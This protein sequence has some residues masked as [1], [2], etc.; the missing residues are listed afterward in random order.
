M[1]LRKGIPRWPFI[2]LQNAKKRHKYIEL[3]H[4]FS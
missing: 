3:D 4:L 1:I 2:S